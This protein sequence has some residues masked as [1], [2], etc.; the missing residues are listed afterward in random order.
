MMR[1]IRF[2]LA[3]C[4]CWFSVSALADVATVEKLLAE[5]DYA[6]AIESLEKLIVEQPQQPSYLFLRARAL[7]EGGQTERAIEQYKGLIQRY[8]QLPEAYNNLAAIYAKQ[9]KLQQAEQ[10]LN[11]AMQTSDA[12]AT[13]YNNLTALNAVKARQAYSKALKMP[14]GSDMPKVRPLARLQLAQAGPVLQQE[15]QGLKAPKPDTNPTLTYKAVADKAD[16]KSK[17]VAAE[18]EQSADEK[19]AIAFLEAWAKAWSAQD[20]ED[21]IGFYHTDYAPGDMSRVEWVEQ[22]RQRLKRPKWIK[23]QLSN[24][25]VQSGPDKGWRVRLEQSYKTNSYSDLMRKEFILKNDNGQWSIIEE[26]GLGFIKR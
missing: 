18:H 19:S 8:P 14:V 21:Y 7:A 24:F 22:R 4:L 11:Q 26:R 15:N 16:I 2:V 23:I 3:L 20:V 17:P 25:Q 6:A 13:V 9:G 1:I 5:K 12:F 10:L